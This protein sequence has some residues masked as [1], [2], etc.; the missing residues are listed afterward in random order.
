VQDFLDEEDAAA[1]KKADR[2]ASTQPEQVT[3]GQARA[4]ALNDTR[5][6]EARKQADRERDEPE[7]SDGKPK[8]LQAVAAPI[9]ADGGSL[10]AK[11][12]PVGNP[13][14]S[15]IDNIA[16]REAEVD[17]DK[18]R[19]TEARKNLRLTDEQIGKMGSAELRAI[20]LQR[21]YDIPVAGGRST[22]AAFLTAQEQDKNIA[23]ELADDEDHPGDTD[24]VPGAAP[25]KV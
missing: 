5:D 12:N 14:G 24:E 23:D 1:Q 4:R 13:T 9:A 2:L 11:G 10:P 6:Y 20:G 16:L 17:R 8:G 25:R 3:A 19:A 15:R 7:V 22:R 18:A 21:G